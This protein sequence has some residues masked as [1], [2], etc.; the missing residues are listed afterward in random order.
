MPLQGVRVLVVEDD[1]DGREITRRMLTRL[2]ATALLAE[3]GAAGLLQLAKHRPD[4]IL[5]D[6]KMPVMDGYEFGQRVKSNPEYRGVRLVALTGAPFEHGY[7]RTWA[8]GFDG[9][10][11]KPV[12]PEK[13][14]T[15]ARIL[16][17]PAVAADRPHG[18]ADLA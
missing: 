10:I 11:E 15:L 18:P 14:E 16:A 2:G 9:H 3:N 12:T 1:P 6:L 4:V 5:A 7:L 8:L 17:G 13:L